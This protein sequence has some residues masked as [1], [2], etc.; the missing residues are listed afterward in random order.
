MEPFKLPSNHDLI[1]IALLYNKGIPDK[2]TMAKMVA[3]TSFVI[4]RLHEN[5]DVRKPSSKEDKDFQQGIDLIKH[6]RDIQLLEKYSIWLTK[7]GYMDTDWKDEEP[8]AIDQFINQ[9]RK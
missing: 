9:K 6:S 4:D 5:Q 3:M 2:E 7:N 8:Y 1:E